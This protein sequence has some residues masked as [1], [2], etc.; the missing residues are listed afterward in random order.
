MGVVSRCI[1]QI[2]LNRFRMYSGWRL[3]GVGA[4]L[5]SR[6][7]SGMGLLGGQ[8]AGP[9]PQ[10]NALHLTSLAFSGFHQVSFAWYHFTVSGSPVEK[11]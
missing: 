6:I 10:E 8:H 7:P 2:S 11:V 4:R 3:L 9:S 5:T 1:S